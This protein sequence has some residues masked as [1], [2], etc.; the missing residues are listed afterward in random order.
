MLKLSPTTKLRL[1]G[2]TKIPLLFLIRPKVTRLDSDCCE[3]L[4]PLNKI[5]KNHVGSMYL[6]TLAIGADA[7]VAVFALY[8]GDSHPI[9]KMIP[10]FKNFKAD[11]LKRA[12]HDVVFRCS[13][14]EQIERMINQASETGNRITEDIPIDAYTPADN[15]EIVARFTLGLSIKMK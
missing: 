5:T 11:F 2:L 6:G 3:I 7:V 4:V 9:K 1:F 14:G 10:I 13:A 15:N 8:K 12:E